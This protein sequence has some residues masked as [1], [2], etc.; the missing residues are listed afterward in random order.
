MNHFQSFFSALICS[1]PVLYTIYEICLLLPRFGFRK[2]K[3]HFFYFFGLVSSFS[4]NR[5]QHDGC[6]KY[7]IVKHFSFPSLC[8]CNLHISYHS[9]ACL[10]KKKKSQMF[11]SFFSRSLS[12]M[13]L[14][15]FSELNEKKKIDLFP[16][17]VK[18][19]CI[20]G[21]FKKKKKIFLLSI[22]PHTPMNRKLS[23]KDDRCFSLV[24]WTLLLTRI[25]NEYSIFQI[26][27]ITMNVQVC[28]IKRK[29]IQN[30][31]NRRREKERIFHIRL[32]TML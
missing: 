15:G 27:F 20:K 24:N 3:K 5:A 18:G 2:K 7:H 17:S 4:E 16:V 31:G 29:F 6:C 25:I 23:V 26:H 12:L 14:C 28:A 10:K 32:L 1:S 8:L 9:C 11:F 30:A 21:F 22:P 19:F 13:W